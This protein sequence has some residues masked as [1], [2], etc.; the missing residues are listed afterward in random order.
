MRIFDW[1]SNNLAFDKNYC[2]WNYCAPGVI[3]FFADR[4]CAPKHLVSLFRFPTRA[5]R[6]DYLAHNV[7][8][9][10]TGD[11]DLLESRQVSAGRYNRSLHGQAH[12]RPRAN[13]YPDTKRTEWHQED[14]T[15][16]HVRSHLESHVRSAMPTY[17][18]DVYIHRNYIIPVWTVNQAYIQHWEVTRL[19]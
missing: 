19:S 3:A 16:G 9:N 5:H 8:S 18:R 11:R 10:D 2:H 14:R 12:E 7:H 13:L 1:Q 15:A 6:P 4:L 17:V